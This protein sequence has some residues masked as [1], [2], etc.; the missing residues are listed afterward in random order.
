MP[1]LWGWVWCVT[2]MLCF[3]KTDF[4]W[5]KQMDIDGGAPSTTPNSTHDVVLTTPTGDSVHIQCLR[6][7]AEG[8]GR[9][10][11]VGNQLPWC[12][13]WTALCEC[14]W[15]LFWHRTDRWLR[16]ESSLSWETLFWRSW[17]HYAWAWFSETAN[18]HNGS[19]PKMGWKHSLLDKRAFI[20]VV[21]A[22][23]IEKLMWMVSGIPSDP[24]SHHVSCKYH[25]LYITLT[26]FLRGLLPSTLNTKA[27]GASK[28]LVISTMLYAIVYRRRIIFIVPTMRTS[29]P[30]LKNII[31]ED[32][33]KRFI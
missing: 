15:R 6:S 8:K 32:H 9:F 25:C 12:H 11:L 5:M 22:S 14:N 4:I 24:V 30:T 29:N 17:S 26:I 20:M 19:W 18:R 31:H 10:S 21:G 13:I 33:H 1:V 28:M 16:K 7:Q 3:T 2:F 23:G 27:H